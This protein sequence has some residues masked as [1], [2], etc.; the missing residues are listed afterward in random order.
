M[1]SARGPGI[2]FQWKALAVWLAIGAVIYAV[3][4]LLRL[5]ERMDCHPTIGGRRMHCRYGVMSPETWSQPPRVV[6]RAP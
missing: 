3:V 2:E 5:P 6:H 4:S 1:L